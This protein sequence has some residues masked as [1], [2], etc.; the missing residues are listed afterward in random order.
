MT[1][2]T[3]LQ[4]VLPQHMISRVV[5]WAT[6]LRS[7]PVKNALIGAFMRGFKPDMSDAVQPDPFSYASFNEFFTRALA[8]GTRPI[9]GDQQTLISPVDGTV[10]QCGAIA[11][12]RLLQAK[13]RD[14]TLDALLAGA[15]G[16]WSS[17]FRDG[18]FATIYLAPYNYHR[19]HMP[20]D[21]RLAD[22]WYVP[23]RLFSVNTVAAAHVPDLFARNERLVLLFDSAAGPFAMIFVGAFN[24][25]SM[26]TV[27][28]GDVTPRRPRQVSQL[29]LPPESQRFLARGAEAG[30]FNMGSTVIL[31]F[32]PGPAT[33]DPQLAAG[34]ILRMGVAIGRLAPGG[35]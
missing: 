9:A 32:G 7:V 15:A 22:I 35:A 3:L 28:H 24:V 14:Y 17:G 30:R 8:A 1:P 27:W 19:I 12:D 10:S 34:R 26:S 23:G 16:R 5:L 33:L 25:G 13:G 6:R 2:F 11:T 21:G 4:Q 18:Q 20:L 29:A 31:L